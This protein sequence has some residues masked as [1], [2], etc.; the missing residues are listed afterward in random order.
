MVKIIQ[1]FILVKKTFFLNSFWITRFNF[2]EIAVFT[3][4]VK[5][6]LSL[7]QH[8]VRNAIF[9]HIQKKGTTR[10]YKRWYTA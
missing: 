3:D 9:D 1:V 2:E 5:M 4:K 7:I 10:W 6:Y 8:Y